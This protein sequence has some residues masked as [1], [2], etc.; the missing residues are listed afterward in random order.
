MSNKVDEG[1]I[2]KALNYAYDKAITNVPGLDS[3]YDLACEYS[4]EPGSKYDQVNSLIRWQNAKSA[5]T[6][7]LTNLGGFVAM[8]VTLPADLTSLFYIQLRMIAAIA[9]IGGYDPKDDKVKT[10]AFGCLVGVE[11]LN[12]TLKD[13]GINIGK[14]LAVQ[15]I[16]KIPREIIVKI[17]QMI[18]KRV[19]TKFGQKGIINLGKYVPLIGGGIGALFN[20]FSTN[21]V[22][23]TARDAFIE[24]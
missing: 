21:T 16:K 8:P 12:Q 18:G 9:I 15:A 17:N 5:T 6:G 7:F 1:V 11:V 3:A 22:G 24:H 23:N 19:L 14:Q 2:S 13:V 20:A 4:R 10:L